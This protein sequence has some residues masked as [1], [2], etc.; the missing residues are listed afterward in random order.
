MTSLG[1]NTTINAA[2][3]RVEKFSGLDEHQLDE[4][5]REVDMRHALPGGRL[6]ELGSED[7]RLLFLLEGELELVASDGAV[8]IV[9]HNGSA[10]LRPVSRLRPS[11]YRVT[12]RTAVDYLLV[13][14]TLLDAYSN[15]EPMGTVVVDESYLL[16]EPNELIDDSATHP[17]MFD[18]FNDLNHGRIAVPSD[19]DVAVR[20][21]RSLTN[22]GTDVGR[23]ARAL[24]ICPALTLKIMRAAKAAKPGRVNIH[25]GKQAVEQLGTEQTL[26]LA[27]KCILCESLR[28]N[29]TVVGEWMH[30]WWERTLRVSAISL[31]LAR[32]SERF[33]PEYAALIGLLHSIA[34]PVLL[35][36]AD[37]HSDLCDSTALDNVVHDN[38]ADLGRILL[39]MWGM[40]REIVDAAA[41]C[42]QWGYDGP[43][44]AD[45]TDIVLVA[46][47]HATIGGPYN[48]R[49]PA[50]EDVPA[51]R[52][53]GLQSASPELGVKIME[54]AD[55]AID[56]AESMLVG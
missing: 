55:H 11:R 51:F 20:V 31:A 15:Q 23:L 13:E 6:L 3:R 7:T 44:A 38:R 33:D 22:Q 49:R 29:S 17:L 26:E 34:E 21:G 8:R 32:M 24:S 43:G 12:A 40:P 16:S 54:A 28:T 1:N 52:R 39:T 48:R 35:G 27:V 4:L 41:R 10:A 50:L 46:Q 5:A 2:L 9:R 25:S 56:E 18:V 37:R 30:N 14:Q 47:W 42:N 45:Y 53:L 36:Y 19:P